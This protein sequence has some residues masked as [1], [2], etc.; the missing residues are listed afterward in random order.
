MQ[1]R[2]AGDDEGVFWENRELDGRLHNAAANRE[3]LN[4]GGD[5]SWPAPQSEWPLHQGR[6]W[7]PPLGFD[8]TPADATECLDGIEMTW[9]ADSDY[10]IQMAR[11]VELDAA[12]PTMRITTEY[13]KTSGEAVRVAP[14]S[15]TQLR[16]PE[17]IYMP[18]PEN[19]THPGGYVRLLPTE[20]ADLRVEG[21]LLSLKRHPS[22]WVKIGADGARMLWVGARTSVLIETETAGSEFPDGGCRTEVYTNNGP[23][24]YVEFEC[25]G[26]LR[27]MRPG[28]RA[29]LV[30]KYSLVSRSESDPS[31]E[32]KK[33]LG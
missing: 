33:L 29:T 14:W 21:R 1:F 24:A 2:L 7:P 17:R 30:T 11:R 10:G 9:P 26:P 18:L 4:L 6:E 22:E 31:R 3:W 19:P 20:P 16:D 5:K 28:D 25:L 27:T 32:A 15:I 23:L 12:E 13:R 8:A